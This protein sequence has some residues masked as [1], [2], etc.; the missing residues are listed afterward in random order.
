MRRRPR[1]CA[2][3]S[4][5]AGYSEIAG[6]DKRSRAGRAEARP[7]RLYCESCAGRVYFFSMVASAS[8]PTKARSLPNSSVIG[9]G[10]KEFLPN[11]PP[12]S[13]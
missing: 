7:A 6:N 5:D 10:M 8:G 3:C 1:G 13:S 12:D 2:T 4:S 9:V 11:I